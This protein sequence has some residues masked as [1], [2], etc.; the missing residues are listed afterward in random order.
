MKVYKLEKLDWTKSPHES[1]SNNTAQG[2][3]TTHDSKAVCI[4]LRSIQ[5]S[6]LKSL[7]IRRLRDGSNALSFILSWVRLYC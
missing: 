4:V 3:L 7:L 5:A 1:T 2:Q 6:V